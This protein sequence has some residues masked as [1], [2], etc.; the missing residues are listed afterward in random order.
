M[1]EG[2]SAT[3]AERFLALENTVRELSM[4]VAYFEE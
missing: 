1:Q 2:A 4:R 3:D